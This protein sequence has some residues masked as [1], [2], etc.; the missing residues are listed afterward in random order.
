[1]WDEKRHSLVLETEL[2]KK[3]KVI[4]NRNIIVWGTGDGG[5][6]VYKILIKHKKNINAFVDKKAKT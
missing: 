2:K 1:M 5:E 3:E 6:L 4:R